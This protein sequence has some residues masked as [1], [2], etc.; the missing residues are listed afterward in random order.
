MNKQTSPPSCECNDDHSL[1]TDVPRREF[2]KL[3]GLSVAGVGISG[4]PSMA[5]PFAAGDVSKPIPLDKKLD[6]AWVKSL[7]DRGQPTTYRGWAELKHIGMPVGGIAAGTVYLGGDG[8]LWC[9]DIFNEHHEGCVPNQIA[10]EPG[11]S[12]YANVVRERDGSNYVRP[13]ADQESPWKIDQ[14]FM[15]SVGKGLDRRNW[16][17]DRTGFEDISFTGQYPVATVSYRNDACPIGVSMEAFSPFIPLNTE[18]SSYPATVLRYRLTNTSNQPQVTSIA[19]YLEN[20]ALRAHTNLPNVDRV[21]SKV[22]GGIA[23]TAVRRAVEDST[24]VHREDILFAD[25]EGD[26]WGEW[27]ATG[28]AFAGGPFDRRQLKPVQDSAGFEGEHFVNTYN[29]RAAEGVNPDNLTGTLTSPMFMVQR[30]Y[31]NLLIGGGK[32]PRDAYVEL[33]VE[34]KSVGRVTGRGDN[35]LRAQSIDASAVEGKQAQIRIV[36]KAQ[37]A[38]A[39]IVVDQILFS[40]GQAVDDGPIDD[41]PDFG[42]VALVAASPGDTTTGIWNPKSLS[43]EAGPWKDRGTVVRPLSER[44]VGATEIELHL[45]PGESKEVAFVIAWHFPNTHFNG[46][47]RW[48]ASRFADAQAVAQEIVSELDELTRVTRLWRDTWYGGTLPNWLLERSI[49]TVDT[50]QTNNAYRF[51]EGQFWAWEGVGCC[52]GTCTHVWHYAQAVG[53]LFPELERDL[54]ERTDYGHGFRETDGRIDFRGGQAGRDATDGQAGVILRTYREHQVSRDDAFLKRVWPM[55][56]KALEFLVA[57]DARDGEPDGVPVG[58]QHNTLDA[59]WFGKV[60]VLVSLYLA[61]LRAG[62]EMAKAVGDGDAAS[63]YH[64]IHDR[65]QKNILSIYNHEFGFFVQEEDPNHLDAI[66]VG[67][68]CYID[69]VMGQWWAFNLGLGRLYDGEKIRSALNRLWDYNFCPDMGRLRD[70][71]EAANLRGRPYALAGDA[72]LVMCSW[73]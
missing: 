43:V 69:Q 8:K 34:G 72:G 9:W 63:R 48:Y 13:T 15:L 42:S 32:R 44:Q 51:E 25:F 1:L 56:K 57:Q 39:Q 67:D 19:G 5:G 4:L 62:E 35:V 66:G 29:T 2:M 54:R 12:P 22:P 55:C 21:L 31:V 14:G 61:A 17:L 20:P 71:V 59:E 37:G 24:V 50:L 68:G 46:R 65:G 33:L 11:I 47:K 53:R 58:E 28:K 16:S 38:W 41:L 36:D 6:A 70:S 64:E 45:D 10:N 52:P 49:V 18:R 40:D 26:D 60:P 7:F 73:P 30:K 23:G 27:T 3:A